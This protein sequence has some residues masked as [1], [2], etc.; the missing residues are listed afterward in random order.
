MF[1]AKQ[2]DEQ[3]SAFSFSSAF[4]P[5]NTTSNWKWNIGWVNVLEY[6]FVDVVVGFIGLT[7]SHQLTTIFDLIGAEESRGESEEKM[8]S[9]ESG[10][11]N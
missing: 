9:Q 2:T 11:R 6:W 3:Q 4:W 10:H 8:P 7:Y 1:A 5:D